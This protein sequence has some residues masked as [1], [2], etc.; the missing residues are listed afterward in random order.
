MKNIMNQE[1]ITQLNL[2]KL[3]LRDWQKKVL[4]EVIAGIENK[5]KF[6][7]S[8][9][10]GVGKTIFSFVTILNF[11]SKLDSS[12]NERYLF[13][14]DRLILI[15]QTKKVFEKYGIDCDIIQGNNTTNTGAKVIIA[16]QQTLIRRDLDQFNNLHSVWVDET[17]ILSEKIREILTKWDLPIIGLSATPFSKYLE[18]I[19]SKIYSP[20]TM[21]QAVKDKVLVE[22]KVKEC[23]PIDMRGAKL[24]YGEYSDSEIEMRAITT[25]DNVVKEYI[26]QASNKKAI[27]FCSTVNHAKRLTDEFNKNNVSA[28]IITGETNDNLREEIINEYSDSENK[29]MVLVSVIALTTG[30]DAPITEVIID[31]RPLS[32]SFSYYLQMIGRGMR[33][34]PE[35]Q[36]CLLL[37]FTGNAR[38]FRDRFVDLYHNG[39]TDFTRAVEYDKRFLLEDVATINNHNPFAVT[40]FKDYEVK[41]FDFFEVEKQEALRI[42]EESENKRLEAIKEENKKRLDQL[43]LEAELKEKSKLE[44]AQNELNQVRNNFINNATATNSNN[45]SNTR[46]QSNLPPELMRMVN[47]IV[48]KNR[49]AQIAYNNNFKFTPLNKNNE[50][51]L[52]KNDLFSAPDDGTTNMRCWQQISNYVCKFKGYLEDE[53]GLKYCK[54]LYKDLTG[55]WAKWGQEI[56]TTED[57]YVSIEMFQAIQKRAV[58]YAR[59]KQRNKSSYGNTAYVA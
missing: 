37:D 29:L 3:E 47:E 31:C 27:A 24:K 45:Y 1:L 44:Q 14:V 20:Y 22:L 25:V 50:T 59:N 2:N 23:K 49:Q 54:A 35:K 38:K 28:K 11:I 51:H 42:A 15:Q 26:N 6:I 33:S 12:K 30:F 13:V 46:P 36:E 41:D 52:E 55:K 4:P 19:Y 57:G 5:E 34:Y 43:M 7:L 8:V 48:Q 18:D 58:N 40:E 10:T 9:P 16:S 32:K 39:V 17:H 53:H 56:E 21:N